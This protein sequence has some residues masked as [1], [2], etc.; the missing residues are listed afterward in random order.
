MQST[1]GRS[2]EKFLLRKKEFDKEI[3]TVYLS[4]ESHGIFTGCIAVEEPVLFFILENC[5][6]VR[7]KVEKNSE[8][9]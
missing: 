9:T 6:S 1:N 4:L 3:M 7:E 8:T 5:L 2:R